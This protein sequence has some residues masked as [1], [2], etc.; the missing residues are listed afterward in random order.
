MILARGVRLHVR[1][2]GISLAVRGRL[3]RRGRDPLVLRDRIAWTAGAERDVRAGLSAHGR[4]LLRRARRP[5]IALTLVA[6]GPGRVSAQDR[7]PP[8]LIRSSPAW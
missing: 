3:R 6:R 5:R 2:T 8:A 1:T 7:V 4:H